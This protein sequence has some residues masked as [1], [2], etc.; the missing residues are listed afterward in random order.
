MA[1]RTI[2]TKLVIEGEAQYKQAIKNCNDVIKTLKSELAATT[3]EYRNNANSMEALKA[4]GE[5][6]TKMYE[7]QKQKVETIRT[8]FDNAKN[9]QNDYQQKIEQCKNKIAELDMQLDKVQSSTEDLS[10]EEADLTKQLEEQKKEL[11]KAEAGNKAASEAVNK[12]KQALNYAQ[13]QLDKFDDEL[14]ENAKKM[15][16]VESGTDGAADSIEEF[17]NS[18]EKSNNSARKFGNEAADAINLFSTNLINS[19][20]TEYAKN[21]TS[22]LMECADAAEEFESGMKETFTLLPH[23][24]DE[25]KEKMSD[26]MLQF[27]SR[28]NVLTEDALPALYNSISA[29]VPEENVFNFLETAQKAAVGGVTD[30]GVAVDGLT[31]ITNAYNDETQDA[32]KTADQMFVAVKLGKTTFGE[33]SQSIYNVVPTAAA[34]K[35][36]FGDV[37][38]ALAVMT[39]QGVPTSVA[40]TKLRQMF[41]ELTDSGSEVSKTFEKV[42]GKSFKKFIQEGNNVQDALQLLETHA[43]GAGLGTD[44]LFSSVEAGSAALL[45]TGNASG[46]FTEALE[47]MQ[48]SAGAVDDA[49][50]EITDSA[51]YQSKRLEVASENLKTATGEALLPIMSQIKSAGADAFNWVAEFIKDNPILVQA[52]TGAA[53]AIAILGAGISAYKLITALATTVT[54]TFGTTLSVALGPIALIGAALGVL[55]PV[56][57]SFVSSCEDSGYQIEDMTKSAEELSDKI[58]DANTKFDENKTSI[59]KTSGVARIYASRLKDLEGEMKSLKKEGKDITGQQAE[60]RVLVEKLNKEVPD[61]NAE[62]DEQTGLLKDGAEA[63]EDQIGSWEELAEQRAY[64]EKYAEIYQAQAEAQLEL[65]ENTQKLNEAQAE[66]NILMNEMDGIY[67]RVAEILGVSKETV[68]EMTAAEWLNVDVAKEHQEEFTNLYMELSELNGEYRENVDQQSIYQDAISISNEALDDATKKVGDAAAVWAEL[69]GNQK[70]SVDIVPEFAEASGV[71]QN[72]TDG[73]IEKLNNLQKAYQDSYNK[74]Y[75]SI[76]SQM[77]LF[78]NYELDTSIS[79]EGISNSLDDQIGFMA[80][81]SNNMRTLSSWGIDQGLLKSLSD[82]SVESASILQAIVDGGQEK[83]GEL[84]EKFAG[85][86]KGKIEF[87]DTVGLMESNLEEEMDKAI[88]AAQAMA[89]GLNQRE[90]A[91]D[92]YAETMQGAIDGLR[93]RYDELDTWHK[94]VQSLGMIGADA[95]PHMAGLATVPYDGYLA[96]LHKGERVLTATQAKAYDIVRSSAVPQPVEPRI[97]SYVPDVQEI[98]QESKGSMNTMEA[99]AETVGR[100]VRDMLHGAEVVLDDEKVG[101]FAVKKVTEEAFA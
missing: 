22:A 44:E 10:D 87:S 30:L 90:Q 38:A 69:K 79:V 73:T 51:E 29:G 1:S 70:E 35:I 8:A 7:A 100:V 53:A 91:Y 32:T 5:V 61:L 23:L 85:V 54:A 47:A 12:H 55:I 86:E 31:S 41:V 45:L 48:Q 60:Y 26:D 49:Y 16:E 65:T 66:A 28:M 4:K 46:K 75:S 88:N 84:N 62:L 72:A 98:A 76:S 59:E 83:I 40:T 95:T 25:A 101:E 81:Y 52:I 78:K 20:I 96:S 99:I 57:G 77:K 50:T 37:S 97:S 17:G 92:S 58:D 56:I 6:L 67:Q 19:K 64:E 42:S 63:L 9:T 2:G 15:Q 68:K 18:A 14:A 3:S 33:L 34:A 89:L 24:T 21:I 13:V 74:A 39:A 82:G 80:N 27:S 11:E 43:K 71:I 94:K 36:S 93:S